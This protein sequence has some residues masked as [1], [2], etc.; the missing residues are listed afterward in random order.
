MKIYWAIL[1][2]SFIVMVAYWG[3]NVSDTISH[4]N[5]HKQIFKYYGINSTI[6]I[7]YLNADGVT[8]P[9]PNSTCDDSCRYLHS[10]NEIVSY[11]LST[12][13][14]AVV[15]IIYTIGLVYIFIKYMKEDLNNLEQEYIE[16]EPN[17][18]SL[19]GGI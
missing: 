3:L 5:V 15:M 10:L 1:L 9:A 19:E 8:Q 11:N 6:N 2:Y 17:D 4:E 14:N 12:A 7:N 13:T 18:L 16:E